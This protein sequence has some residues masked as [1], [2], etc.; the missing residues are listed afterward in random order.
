M[1]CFIKERNKKTQVLY[2]DIRH[3]AVS[4]GPIDL[5]LSD[6]SIEKILKRNK[7]AILCE[8]KIIQQQKENSKEK[9]LDYLE[10]IFEFVGK[11]K[12]RNNGRNPICINFD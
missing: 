1:K 9:I 5:K 8:T 12:L 6:G 7:I 4:V 3:K 2:K 11:Y 10:K